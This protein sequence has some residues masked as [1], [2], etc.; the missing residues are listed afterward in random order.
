MTHWEEIWAPEF[1]QQW[2][3][4]LDQSLSAHVFYH[5]ALIKAWLD[6]YLPLRHI[7]PLFLVAESG[8][9]K[10]LFPLILWKRNWKNAFQNLLVPAGYADYDYH[11][12]IVA[13]QNPNELPDMV[14]FWNEFSEILLTK[15]CPVKFDRFL[16]EG[17]CHTAKNPQA[18]TWTQNDFCPWLDLSPFQNPEDFLAS[19]KKSLRGDLRRQ[20]RRVSETGVLQYE[21]F[22]SS[23]LEKIQAELFPFLSAHSQRWPE[24]YKAPYFHQK[25]CEQGLKAGILHFSR[26]T[27]D[28]I[29]AAWHMGFVFK[30]RFYYYLPAHEER[31][32]R[33]SPGKLILLKCIED[34]IQKGIWVYDFL[35]GDESYKTG[36]TNQRLPLWTLQLDR[37]D[38]MPKIRNKM[39]GQVKPKI[40]SLAI[41]FR[42][43]L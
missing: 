35:R 3:T 21:V 30:K 33:F 9:S 36:W 10:V 23:Q 2:L 38:L 7:S 20:E 40:N 43:L 24:A 1:E 25:I 31:Y 29:S 42:R 19:L 14:S 27:I 5:P 26:I 13:S 22:S 39:V 12:P 8:E 32:Q 34:A 11:N 16:L 17:I 41:Q 6:T 28:G 15:K 4:W 37:E 18:E